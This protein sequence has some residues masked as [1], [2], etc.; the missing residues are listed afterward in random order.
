MRDVAVPGPFALEF[1][2][3]NTFFALLT[4]DDQVAC[5]RNVAERLLPGG[6]F[7]IEAFVPDL[8]R[9]DRGQRL[10]V[11]ELG[12]ARVGIEASSHDASAQQVTTQE[13]Q[14]TPEGNR[15]FV[16]ITLRYA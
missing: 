15:G 2:L 14:I 1:V 5:F 12:V 7:V 13:I 16:P 9:F 6:R 4:Q 10:A 8:S 3:L 11:T